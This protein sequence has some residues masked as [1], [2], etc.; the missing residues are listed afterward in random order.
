MPGDGYSEGGIGPFRPA[1]GHE[2]A[3]SQTS[4]ELGPHLTPWP[5]PRR[6]SEVLFSTAI[7]L[8]ESAG[9]ALYQNPGRR[10]HALEQ[11]VGQAQPFH[12][13]EREGIGEHRSG[14]GLG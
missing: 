14:V 7:E 11:R 10:P 12:G 6:L 3:A 9:L 4:I 2:L 8:F 1:Q 5:G 13:G